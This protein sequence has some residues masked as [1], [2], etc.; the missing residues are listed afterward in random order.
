MKSEEYLRLVTW[1]TDEDE[2]TFGKDSYMVTA[3]ETSDDLFRESESMHNCVRIYVSRVAQRSSRIYLLREKEK[4][5]KSYGTIEVSGDGSRLIQAKAFG[6]RKLPGRAQKFVV[7]WCRSKK[8]KISTWDI[9]ER[10]YGL[11]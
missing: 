8:I 7:K 2:E 10:P 1:L 6:N 11:A 9:T 4:P 3:P 5:D